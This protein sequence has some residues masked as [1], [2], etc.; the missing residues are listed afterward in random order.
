MEDEATQVFA[1]VSAETFGFH[2]PFPLK[3]PNG[4]IDSGLQCPLKK[5][6]SYVYE[7]KLQTPSFAPPVYIT[8]N[9]DE[10]VF[11]F[12][13][14]KFYTLQIRVTVKWELLN[15]KNEPIVCFK[16]PARIE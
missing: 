10:G 7:G 16:V 8:I 13:K 12:N 15:E 5:Q 14:T 11:F 6:T 4:C 2:V 9:I 3:N 1:I